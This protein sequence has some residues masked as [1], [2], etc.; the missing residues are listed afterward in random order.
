MPM[1]RAMKA[2]RSL[3]FHRPTSGALTTTLAA[4]PSTTA[5]ISSRA[6]VGSGVE[7][8]MAS[9][10]GV[11]TPGAPAPGVTAPRIPCP[12]VPAP[13]VPDPAVAEGVDLS[14]HQVKRSVKVFRTEAVIGKVRVDVVGPAAGLERSQ[15]GRG[16]QAHVGRFGQEGVERSRGCRPIRIDQTLSGT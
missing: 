11:A 10:P 8:S 4:P 13:G 7:L 9:A 15:A 1:T 6:R 14:S 5:R 12:G 16:H 2:R 3:A